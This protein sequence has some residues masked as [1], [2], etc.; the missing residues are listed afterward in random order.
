[1]MMN[2]C[3][4]LARGSRRRGFALIEA[5]A[6]MVIV[7]FGMLA[8]VRV[9]STLT[10]NADAARQRSEATRLAEEKI[11]QLRA[12]NSVVSGVGVS[13]ADMTSSSTPE[14]PSSPSDTTYSRSWTLGGAAADPMRPI[15]VTVSWT[16]RT[17]TASSVR[18]NSV[19]ARVDP[20]LAGSLSF[21]LPGNGNIKLPKSRNLNIPI[22]AVNLGGGQSAYNLTSGSNTFNFAVVFSNVTGYVVMRC[23]NQVHSSS[24]LS[25]CTNY[26]AYIA[27]GYIAKM[28][29][30]GNG[31]GNSGWSVDT[32]TWLQSTS[33][34]KGINLSQITPSLS[35]GSTDCVFN[36]AT[37]QNTGAQIAGYDYYLCVM[38]VST[39]GGT[40]S[41]KV[42]LAGVPAGYVVCRYQYSSTTSNAN[43]NNVQ[44]YTNVNESLDQQNYAI[45]QGNNANSCPTGTVLHQT[46]TSS[47]PCP[48]SPD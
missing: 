3:D 36:P 47:S 33:N 25:S 43:E 23:T 8:L 35:H 30:S 46:C 42:Q 37:D 44:P 1:M 26:N 6:A 15:Q 22:Q 19:I 21:P 12:Y 27:A 24:D 28:N 39:A 16:D 18:L 32:S 17:G 10:Q 11:E 45:A 5:L 48:A 34:F 9:Q 41:G 4:G 14:T 13:W 2:E 29:S 38:Q 7:G 31:N 20:A 40:W